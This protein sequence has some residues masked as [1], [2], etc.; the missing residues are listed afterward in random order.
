MPTTVVKTIRASG[1]DYT[2][3]SAWEAANQGD[4]VT[5]DE[6]RVAECY[7]DW[8]SG[9]VDAVTIDGSTTDATRYLKITVANGHRHTGIP[10]TGFFARQTAAFAH[11]V[12]VLD[13]YT[14]IGW[15]D[16]EATGS[17]A[18]AFSS[19]VTLSHFTNCIG[20]AETSA[21]S[22]AFYLAG[23]SVL[24]DCLAYGGDRGISL[25]SYGTT[26]VYNC[27]V[28]G[29]AV[30]SLATSFVTFTLKNSVAHGNTTNYSGT[31]NA[32]STNNATSSAS[33]DAPGASSVWGITSTDF[34]DAANKNFHLAADS[35]LIGAGT[36]LYSTFTTDID[37]DEWPSS[38]AWDIGFDYYVAT[39]GATTLT[40]AAALHAHSAD[41]LALSV[42]STL[43]I[44]GA[45]HAHAA[46]AI[47]LTT[48]SVLA[49]AEVLH[50]HL[51]DNV[52]LEVAG[53]DNLIIADAAH[54]HGADNLSL[55]SQLAL[56]IAE[57]AHAH[58]ADGI[59]ITSEHVLAV[60]DAIHAHLADNIILSV[61]DAANLIVAEA[62]HGH[63]ADNLALTSQLALV[64]ADSSH[65]H[66][67]DSV[68]LSTEILLAL[69]D[70]LHGHA[71]DNLTLS[72]VP[73]LT[74]AEATHTHAADALALTSD[75]LLMI[76]DA[77]HAHLADNVS[78]TYADTLAIMD[79]MHAHFA[80]NVVLNFADLFGT[81]RWKFSA[82]KRDW[83]F[84]APKR[85]WRFSA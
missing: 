27:V 33:D 12:R 62:A 45:A 55:T 11:T 35:A 75:S 52:A 9:L 31:F 41:S 56:S 16:A 8:P 18:H 15:F 67:A 4:L 23:S 65:A 72:D 10:K 6:V 26:S 36:N 50:S 2:T 39:G 54:A 7:N 42:D 40:I 84:S 59:V 43:A 21:N 82:P 57:S 19:S 29:C 49:V 44:A 25:N 47:D 32:A 80:D 20:K 22:A 1:G 64:L 46:D 53:A 3:L 69:A 48:L 37:G 51:A 14:R 63:T 66:A 5:A 28:T 61:M 71:A 70:A 74:I 24:F 34:V 58:T 76:A 13:D 38:G 68:A 81:L 77:V 78:M 17:T 60:A 83:S 79:S 85:D 73:S 30:G